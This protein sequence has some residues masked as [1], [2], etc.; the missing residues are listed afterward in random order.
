MYVYTVISRTV[1]TR[2]QLSAKE[3]ANDKSSSNDKKLD[4]T[5]FVTRLLSTPLPKG[6]Y[7]GLA[8]R[9]YHMN[10]CRILSAMNKPV[11][12]DGHFSGLYLIDIAG[13]AS[14]GDSF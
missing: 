11:P 10:G 5:G 13:L 3:I 12:A 14:R 8:S 9:S 4:F 6:K 1:L 7:M 2:N